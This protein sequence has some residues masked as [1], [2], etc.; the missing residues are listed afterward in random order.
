MRSIFSL[1]FTSVVLVLPCLLGAFAEEVS[2]DPVAV[3]FVHVT[4][5]LVHTVQPIRISQRHQ[6]Q[7]AQLL[8]QLHNGTIKSETKS[9][10]QRVL[11]ALYSID[12]FQY[13]K[14]A[15]FESSYQKVPQRQK[16]VGI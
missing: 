11:E 13:H 12:S 15:Q 3:V 6:R 9:I 1:L 4:T 10:K 8:Q 5:I 2:S 14:L 16:K 7:R